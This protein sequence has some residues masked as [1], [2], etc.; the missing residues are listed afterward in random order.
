MA[1][2]RPT[3]RFL[4]EAARRSF[5]HGSITD[6]SSNLRFSSPIRGE[7]GFGHVV[8]NHSVG[9]ERAWNSGGAAKC[10]LDPS[11][12][13]TGPTP[14]EELRH[15]GVFENFVKRGQRRRHLEPHRLDVRGDLR[16]RIRSRPSKPSGH[17]PSRMEQFTPR[18]IGGFIPLVPL[19]SCGRIGVLSQ[20]SHP[21][22]SSRP[23]RMSYSSSSRTLPM[24]SGCRLMR[25]IVRAKSCPSVSRGWAFP[26]NTI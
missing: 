15:E 18:C 7:V 10:P 19:A 12:R 13:K 2:C 22:V 17:Q 3:G 23:I 14:I 1:S 25:W 5:A 8:R 21:E 11:L 9:T 20:T 26:A 24:N 16:S 6:R 4:P